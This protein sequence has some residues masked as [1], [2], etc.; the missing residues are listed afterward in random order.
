MNV[1]QG[2]QERKKRSFSKAYVL[3]GQMKA[4]LIDISEGGLC[5]Q[6]AENHH[7][8]IRNIKEII[9]HFEKSED[10]SLDIKLSM[11]AKVCRNIWDEQ[12]NCYVVGLQIQEIKDSVKDDLKSLINRLKESDSDWEFDFGF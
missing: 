2:F 8:H 4:E 5:F 9:V 10:I 12:K 3:I 6:T 11:S 1:A 7:E